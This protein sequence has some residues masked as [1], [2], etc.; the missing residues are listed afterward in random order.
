MC[1]VLCSKGY[2]G[3]YDKKVKIDNIANFKNENNK[4]IIHAGTKFINNDLHAVGGRVLNVVVMSD[5]FQNCK[6]E[7]LKILK[8]I[9]WKQGF[10]RKDIGY[11]VTNS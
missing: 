11:K 2:P 1:F 7:A 8:K 5:T 3:E 6:D 4:Y 9:D 10:Y